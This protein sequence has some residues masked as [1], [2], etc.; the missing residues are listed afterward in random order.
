MTGVQTCALPICM[1][2]PAQNTAIEGEQGIHMP[3]LQKLFGWTGWIGK[4]ANS[5]SPVFGADARTGGHVIDR[6][7]ERRFIR[8]G[9]EAFFD[10]R[11]EFESRGVFSRKGHT[12]CASANPQHEIDL[13]GGNALCS[14]DKIALVLT[15]LVINNDHDPAFLNCPDSLLNGLQRHECDFLNETALLSVQIEKGPS[16]GLFTDREQG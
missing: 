10:D 5:A 7:H 13:L 6:P 16:I 4:C 15:I 1:S 9:V 3:G 11:S 2:G 8:G 14:T 12:Q